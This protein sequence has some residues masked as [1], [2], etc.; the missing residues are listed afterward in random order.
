M[1]VG[2][3]SKKSGR[4]RSILKKQKVAPSPSTSNSNFSWSFAARALVALAAVFVVW[5][6]GVRLYDKVSE[7]F[8]YLNSLIVLSPQE[9]KIEVINS[10]GQPLPDDVRNEVYRA[11]QKHLK[12]GH[13]SDLLSL[14]KQID[15]LGTL[16]NVRL[17]RPVGDTLVI[18][19]NLRQPILYVE[20]FGKL[21]LLTSD[22]TLYGE[23]ADPGASSSTPLAVVSGVFDQRGTSAG[24]ASSKINI[25]ADERA[26]LLDAVEL[27]NRASEQGLDVRRIHYQKFRGFSLTTGEGSEIIVGLGSFDYKVKKLRG[28]LDGL[29]RDG[30]IASRIELDYEGKAFIKERRL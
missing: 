9:W 12:S 13:S 24:D 4:A 20:A 18:S 19:A 10:A 7:S 17:I 3:F 26:H 22:G 15:G 6:I 8:S 11:A 2:I 1:L 25:T 28:I 14:A 27:L 5:G 16:D 29:K 30:V 23:V 21:R